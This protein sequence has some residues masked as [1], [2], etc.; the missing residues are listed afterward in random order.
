MTGESGLA[1]VAKTKR[2]NELPSSSGGESGY[3]VAVVVPV[4]NRIDATRR[5]LKSFESVTYSSYRII[6]IDDGST[7]S[8]AEWVATDY[9]QVF[10]L[11]GDGN[12]WWTGATNLGVQKALE[13]D[14]D[15]ILTINNDSVVSPDFLSHLVSTAVRNPSTIVGS[16]LCRLA[17]PSTVWCT[18]G[19]MDWSRGLLFGLRQVGRPLSE[20]LE[21]QQNPLSVELLTGC[22]TLIPAQC[23]RDAGLY[24]AR[25]FPQYHA[26]SELVMRAATKG[27]SAVVELNAIVW[28]DVA[29]TWQRKGWLEVI[30]SRR[31][32][33]YWRPI[34]AISF[35]YCRW[36][37]IPFSLTRYYLQTFLL[38][39]LPGTVLAIRTLLSA[40]ASRRS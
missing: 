26:D 5:F 39:L 29:L 6:L 22:S 18:G 7:D 1:L 9:P 32:P 12:L 4:H 33:H 36:V 10:V 38:L 19:F 35:V 27:Y 17:E 30:F 16:C 34:L 2:G 21:T 15:F 11:H 40:L 23:F 20:I 31:S 28:N 3:R 25:W 37:L 8:T 14:F 13:E 24:D